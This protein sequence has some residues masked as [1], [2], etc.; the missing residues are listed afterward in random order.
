[1][2]EATMG[3][4]VHTGAVSVGAGGDSHMCW[5]LT[6]ADEAA[7]SVEEA[8][9]AAEALDTSAADDLDDAPLDF[10]EEGGDEATDDG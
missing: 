7:P 2:A 3:C 10:D 6:A 4:Y 5:V 1:M 9:G 8:E